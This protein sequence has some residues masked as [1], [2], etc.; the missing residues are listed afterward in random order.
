MLAKTKVET[1]ITGEDVEDVELASALLVDVPLE[2]GVDLLK[3]DQVPGP[4]TES[5]DNVAES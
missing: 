1:L 3:Q 5:T 2:V 4:P